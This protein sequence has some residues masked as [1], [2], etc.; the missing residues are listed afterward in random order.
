VKRKT[1]EGL[2][3]VL[4][5]LAGRQHGVFSHAQAQER[6]ADDGWL[7]RRVQGGELERVVP[8][9][10]RVHGHHSS[11][12]QLVMVAVLGAGPGA[13]A[14]HRTAAA[15]LRLDGLDEGVVELSVP[16]ARRYRAVLAHRIGDLARFDVTNVEGIPCTT[17]T[18]TCVDLGAVVDDDVVEQALECAVRRGLTTLGYA[19]RRAKALARRGRAGPASLLRVLARR[20]AAANGSDL[21]TRFEQLCRA[22]GIFGLQ[23]QVPIG[24]YVADFA[25]PVRRVVVELDGLETHATSQAL[26]ADLARQN[27]LVLQGW[28]VLRYTWDDVT[29]RGAALGAELVDG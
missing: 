3:P 12:R 22:A 20:Q 1:T 26:Q 28:T 21:E 27:F 19:A 4:W 23:R 7:L 9:V 15:L 5:L 2:V 13:V 6:G 29:Q 8:R 25:D 14:S 18:R 10:Y 17:G 24:P 16:P 11:F